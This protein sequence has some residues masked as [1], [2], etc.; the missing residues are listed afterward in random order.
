M[1]HFYKRG[2][3]W[4]NLKETMEISKERKSRIMAIFSEKYDEWFWSQEGKTD[5]YE[6][7]A[8]FNKF[9]TKMSNEFIQHSVG[10][11]PDHRKKRQTINLGV[12]KSPKVIRELCLMIPKYIETLPLLTES[13]K[14]DILRIYC[15]LDW[16][17]GVLH[18]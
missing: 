9:K 18:Y 4:W 10:Q 7:E 14:K 13:L 5:T 15:N 12:L 2:D 8:S 6:C 17:I 1:R 11:K 3:E 16:I